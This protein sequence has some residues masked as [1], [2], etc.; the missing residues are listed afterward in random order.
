MSTFFI[1]VIVPIYNVDKYL[2]DCIDSVINQASNE[3]ELIL[4]NDG[5]ADGSLDI[6]MSYRG[7]PNVSIINQVNSG[8]SRAR[9]KG[10]HMAKGDYVWFVDG[11]DYIEPGALSDVLSKIQEQNPDIVVGQMRKFKSIKS[12]LVN[13][14][15]SRGAYSAELSARIEHLS[16]DDIFLAILQN[17]TFQPS[18]CAN[19]YRRNLFMKNNITLDPSLV[20]NEDI[21]CSMSLYRHADSIGV[22]NKTIYNYRQSRQGSATNSF[23]ASRVLS[24]LEFIKKQKAIKEDNNELNEAI[25]NYLAYQFSI[26]LGSYALCSPSDRALLRPHIIQSSAILGSAKSKKPKL[27]LFLCKSLGLR[28]TSSILGVF[29]RAKRAMGV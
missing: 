18:L 20:N 29:I 6:C 19:I 23:S 15:Q 4:V 8:V 22:V 13:A 24:S 1:S 16:G 14:D 5:S 7:Y 27:T 11:D 3:V 2:K 9:N 10:L 17:N 12:I 21:D 25:G 28:A 26:T